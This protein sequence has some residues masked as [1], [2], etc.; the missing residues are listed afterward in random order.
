MSC[1]RAWI[2]TAL[3]YLSS[4]GTLE[5]DDLW[6]WEQQKFSRRGRREASQEI[7][8]P[9]RLVLQIHSPNEIQHHRLSTR[10]RE[11]HR[12]TGTYH[13]RIHLAQASF[14]VKAFG[15]SFV[16]DLELNH[17]LL[18][19][20]Y[21]ERHFGEEGNVT[22]NKGGEHCYYHGKVRGD[23]ESIVAVS[24]CQGLHGVFSTGKYTYIIKPLTS[25][26]EETSQEHMVSRS[27]RLSFQ[28]TC[29]GS[30]CLLSDLDW[31]IPFNASKTRRKRQIPYLRTSVQSETKYIELIVVNDHHLIEQLRHSV[32]ATGNF[33]KS[34]VNL[35]DA[36]YKE[37]LRTRIV[38]VAMETWATNDKIEVAEDPVQTLR[39]FMKYRRE[40]IQEQGD[41][42]HLFSGRTFKSSRSGTAYYQ[43]ICSLT[44]AGGV[45]EYGNVGAMAITLAQSLGQNIGMMWNKHRAAAS[46]CKCPDVWLGCIMED[47]GYYLPR[48]FSRCS[49]DEYN[50]FLQD[51]GGSCLFNKPTKL[52]DPPE[53]GNGYMEAGE[54]CDCG[55]PLD[56]P[57]AGGN[58]CKKCTLSHDAMCSDGLCCRRCKCPSNVHKLDGY[59]CDS[60]QGRC[61]S[62]RCKNRDGQCIAL[63]GYG[64][65]DRFC[66]EKL[67][68]EGK[69][70]GNCGKEGETWI[71]CNK[72]DVL[73]GFLLCS[74]ASS[75]PRFGDLD[76]EIASMTFYHQNRYVDCRGGHVLMDDGTDV[77]Y[78]EDGTPCGPNMMCLDR[79][80]LPL[81][82]FNLSSCPGST[83]GRV[84]FNH[85]V[86]SNGAQC[87][88][89]RDW[90]GKDCSVYDPVPSPSPT[91]ET[92]NYKET[93]GEEDLEVPRIL[94][95]YKLSLPLVSTFVSTFRNI[96]LKKKKKGNFG[97]L[98]GIAISIGQ[99]LWVLMSVLSNWFLSGIYPEE[100]SWGKHSKINLA[101]NITCPAQNITCPPST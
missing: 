99:P 66:Y 91:D 36:I 89:D 49:I 78:I 70:A 30:E 22:Q 55:S 45:N 40:S 25:D 48:K 96:F 56:C 76:G 31:F 19:S 75:S 59:S 57:K 44:R 71:Q 81:T 34:V 5:E 86:C 65:A 18:S 68:I 87:I 63:W 100:I 4:A 37:Q 79:R 50:R 23:A 41:A 58:C 52:L 27:P 53:C 32:V 21:V 88:C 26:S 12:R 77:S 20:Q 72:Q 38:L 98:K 90:T 39:E 6:H 64:S 51:G 97:C 85:G 3:I 61:Y 28:E 43:G 73:C 54:E 62:G 82:A 14:M 42:V 2:I 94:L 9:Q 80:C 8:S 95:F 17:H 35:A 29:S 10:V 93:S 1:G 16:L 46:E 74:N 13:N 101:Q 24:T 11:G 60:G 33:A 84:C 92:E 7:T 83:D 47:T 15:S 69:E 67:N